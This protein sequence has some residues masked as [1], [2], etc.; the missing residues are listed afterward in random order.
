MAKLDLNRLRQQAINADEARKTE[1]AFLR[2]LLDGIY[3]A[4]FECSVDGIVALT[5]LAHMSLVSEGFPSEIRL[6]GE[7]FK[8]CNIT[9]R[10]EADGRWTAHAAE[11]RS[12]RNATP[13][14]LIE[15]IAAA[16]HIPLDDSTRKAFSSVVNPAGERDFV[17]LAK[18]LD[19]IPVHSLSAMMSNGPVIAARFDLGPV[20]TG[21]EGST[22]GFIVGTE[23]IAAI[24]HHEDI[25]AFARCVGDAVAR[26]KAKA[27]SSDVFL[28]DMISKS[29]KAA[30]KAG[31]EGINDLRL[32]ATACVEMFD[33]HVPPE[34]IEDFLHEG[35]RVGFDI[36]KVVTYNGCYPSTAAHEAVRLMDVN[37]VRRLEALG[38][39]LA[40]ADNV[41][42]LTSIAIDRLRRHD[43][44]SQGFAMLIH[45]VSTHGLSVSA[46][47]YESLDDRAS[48]CKQAIRGGYDNRNTEGML[49]FIVR[50]MG[51]L[52]KNFP[53]LRNPKNARRKAA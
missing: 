9:C 26:G 12:T 1:A 22:R 3:S 46:E 19:L 43:Q 16:A 7:K 34:A 23:M 15:S 31:L 17:H 13:W 28:S 27:V 33:P 4:V 39:D 20:K 21:P 48:E 8:G 53:S 45:L 38:L 30:G 52:D 11:I 5:T 35:V 49:D 6:K 44:G 50:V 51:F 41:R 10:R 2:S 36:N 18:V 47:A 42:S 32:P 40:A 24:D 37:A 25:T 14:S 29:I